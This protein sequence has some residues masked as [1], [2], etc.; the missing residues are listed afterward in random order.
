MFHQINGQWGESLMLTKIKRV[1]FEVWHQKLV[2]VLEMKEQPIDQTVLL[3][4]SDN[5]K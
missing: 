4:K 1:W 5:V 3:L 2:N